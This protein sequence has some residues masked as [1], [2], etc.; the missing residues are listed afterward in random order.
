LLQMHSSN[1]WAGLTW[2]LQQD[3]SSIWCHLHRHKID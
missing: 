3:H 1:K 2:K